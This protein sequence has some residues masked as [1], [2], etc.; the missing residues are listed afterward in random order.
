MGRLSEY[1]EELVVTL[2]SELES[3]QIQE[4]EPPSMSDEISVLI[5]YLQEAQNFLQEGFSE[6]NLKNLGI[7]GFINYLD[8]DELPTWTFEV[9]GD[10]ELTAAID[11]EIKKS[12]CYA[13][14]VGPIK[15]L[16]EERLQQCEAIVPD[17]ESQE[18][19]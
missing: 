4:M 7:H 13:D 5:T 3:Q 17:T 1:N 6:Y 18:N 11:E 16:L 14:R 12:T 15:Q 2:L 8:L 10:Q 9:F 19:M